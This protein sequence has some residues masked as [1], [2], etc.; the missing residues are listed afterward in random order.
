MSAQFMVDRDNILKRLGYA[1]LRY[2]LSQE[3]ESHEKSKYLE[4]ER[5][6]WKTKIGENEGYC[7]NG[8][9][10][11]SLVGLESTDDAAEIERGDVVSGGADIFVLG[12]VWRCCH[13]AFP[14]EAAFLYHIDDNTAYI[15]NLEK[16]ASQIPQAAY[17]IPIPPAFCRG[18]DD[19]DDEGEWELAKFLALNLMKS[20]ISN[21]SGLDVVWELVSNLM[22]VRY[23]TYDPH[24]IMKGVDPS[25]TH[26]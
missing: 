11:K 18:S 3:C 17:K 2:P 7:D 13:A 1:V 4:L 25:S 26:L 8:G 24:V 9:A 20:Q 14:I 19:V 5:E 15:K 16:L 10:E 23:M 22:F 6:K 12:A 21:S